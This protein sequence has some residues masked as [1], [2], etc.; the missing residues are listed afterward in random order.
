MRSISDASNEKSEISSKYEY[1]KN[2]VGHNR[3]NV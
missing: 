3:Y 2:L 1:L